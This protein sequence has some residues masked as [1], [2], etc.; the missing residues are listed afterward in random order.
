MTEV[1]AA[2]TQSWTCS[3][4]KVYKR[5]AG[6]VVKST[7]TFSSPSHLCFVFRS[8]VVSLGSLLLLLPRLSRPH[9]PLTFIAKSSEVITAVISH[10]MAQVDNEVKGKLVLITGASGG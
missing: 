1:Q 8:S 4:R 3:K 9:F 6:P 5:K 7:T 10:A 2:V